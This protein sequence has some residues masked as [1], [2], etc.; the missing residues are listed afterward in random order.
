[1]GHKGMAKIPP[2]CLFS[3]RMENNLQSLHWAMHLISFVLVHAG[4][5]QGKSTGG[6]YP[7]PEESK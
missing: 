7:P 5:Q 3:L 4:Q 2:A 1:M 6:T